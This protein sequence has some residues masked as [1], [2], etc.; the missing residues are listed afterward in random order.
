MRITQIINGCADL[1]LH[2]DDCRELA[3]LL[4]AVNHHD[5]DRIRQLVEAY[6]ALFEGLMTATAAQGFA[7]V[8]EQEILSL[9]G[10]LERLPGPD[11]P[12]A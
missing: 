6:R 3:L 5:D 11:T 2:A 9:T 7:P 8:R 12:A 10:L 4:A 1:T